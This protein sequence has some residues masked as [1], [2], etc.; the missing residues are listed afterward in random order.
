MRHYQ[1]G[2]SF[3]GPQGSM[4]APMMVQNPSNGPYMGVPQAMS[5]YTPQMQMYSPSP[6][7]AYP[8]HAPPPQPHSGYPSP[9][10][11]APMMMHQNSQ[12]GQPPQ[13]MMFMSPGQPGQPGFGAQPAHSESPRPV[14]ISFAAHPPPVPTGRGGY[15]QQQPHFSS[16]P[17][18]AHHFP[19]NHR[20]PSNGYNQTPQ[21]PPQMSSNTPANGGAGS[22]AA[23]STDEAK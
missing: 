19:P 1:G 8:Q 5:P 22:H 10:R 15:P 16:S 4:G 7:H 12:S 13:P 11:G 18:Q 2:P 20:T 9:S 17:H 6:G 14:W 3:S 23:E 21:M